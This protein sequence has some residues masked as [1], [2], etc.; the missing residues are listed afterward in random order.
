MSSPEE[1]ARD[2]RQSWPARTA[3]CQ[4]PLLHTGHGRSLHRT[5]Q[6]F[7]MDIHQA[8]GSGLPQK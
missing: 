1:Y 4:L 6:S 8:P 2:D 7:E 3:S 5:T